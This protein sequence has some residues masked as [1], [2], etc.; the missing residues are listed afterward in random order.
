[1]KTA[2]LL[3]MSLAIHLAAKGQDYYILKRSETS[4]RSKSLKTLLS[5]ANDKTAKR[6]I[7]RDLFNDKERVKPIQ[8]AFGAGDINGQLYSSLVNDVFISK[9]GKYLG[10]ISLGSVVSNTSSSDSSKN[11]KASD[12][13]NFF[14]GGGNVFVKYAYLSPLGYKDGYDN[15]TFVN[16]LL[17]R[18]ASN[19]PKLGQSEKLE[20]WNME[21]ADE[22]TISLNG[23]NNK[24]GVFLKP[25]LALVLG[26]KKFSESILQNSSRSFAYFQLQG[27]VKIGDGFLINLAVR[28]VIS[29]ERS[30]Y[31]KEMQFSTIGIQALI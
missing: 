5:A 10:E 22:F 9:K 1:M 7:N 20:S 8:L 29:K 15:F 24:L 12:I 23:Q 16:V 13:N 4:E 31:F 21:I 28:P 25:K 19:L 6:K 11:Q 14:N 27:A 30:E 18:V 2:I 26:S 17:F 3:F